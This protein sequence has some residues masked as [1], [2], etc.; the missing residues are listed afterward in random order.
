M[1]R[2]NPLD[3]ITAVVAVTAALI[4]RIAAL[5]EDPVCVTTWSWPFESAIATPPTGLAPGVVL[6][7]LGRAEL[8]VPEP[9][10][11]HQ[12]LGLLSD[13]PGTVAQVGGVL[14]FLKLLRRATRFGVLTTDTADDL[15]GL[16]HYLVL[17]LP[18]AA[19]VESLARTTLVHTAVTY[20]AGWGLFFGDWRTPW[21]AVLVGVGLLSLARIT[22]TSA[23]MRA[24]LETTV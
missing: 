6:G 23:E 18:G 7:D 3:P 19:L 17:A 9:A 13:L 16:G 8:C 15:R 21:W 2:K 4:A 1:S 11:W 10:L 22:R 12:V 5:V 14:L 20:D 24:E